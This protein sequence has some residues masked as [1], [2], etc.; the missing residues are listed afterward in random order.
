MATSSTARRHPPLPAPPTTTQPLR[1]L[2]QDKVMQP[3]KAQKTKEGTT[4]RTTEQDTTEPQPQ[5]QR[6]NVIAAIEL[7]DGTTIQSHTN[8]DPDKQQQPIIFHKFG[9]DE[10]KLLEGM[11]TDATQMKL[12]KV[13]EE[14]D[15]ATLDSSTIREAIPT[16]W[17][18]R[19]KGLQVRPRIVAKGYIEKVDDEDS[20]YAST[21]MFA[22]LRILPR[23]YLHMATKGTRPTT[24]QTVATTKSPA[25]TTQF[26]KGM[27]R[28][29]S[30]SPTRTT[31]QT[32]KVLTQ[33]LHFVDDLLSWRPN[34]SQQDLSDDPTTSAT[35]THW[36]H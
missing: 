33:R 14:V 6:T 12:H 9:F 7:H 26:T 31:L 28:L 34:Y 32:T 35:Q 29:L 2:N 27:A 18:H 36:L 15:I 22:I 11:E 24:K 13:Y 19:E 25:R 4:V 20:V 3:T 8:D 21:P 16:R 30:A 5:R 17:V 10:S 1:L 23:T